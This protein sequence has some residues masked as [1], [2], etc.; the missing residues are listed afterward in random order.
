[1]C[2]PRQVASRNKYMQTALLC[3]RAAVETVDANVP[4]VEKKT[5]VHAAKMTHG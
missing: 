2:S 4:R 5:T 1:M 3:S